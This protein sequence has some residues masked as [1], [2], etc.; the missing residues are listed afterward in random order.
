MSGGLPGSKLRAV[1]M[2][3]RPGYARLA[4]AS[5]GGDSKL[6]FRQ[7]NKKLVAA[8][9]QNSGNLALSGESAGSCRRFFRRY[10]NQIGLRRFVIWGDG[11]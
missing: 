3:R 7:R 11:L 2:P 9:T 4:L 6:L 1:A 5:E 8:R 10:R